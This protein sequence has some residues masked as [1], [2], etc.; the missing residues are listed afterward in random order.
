METRDYFLALY[1]FLDLW[2]DVWEELGSLLGREKMGLLIFERRSLT[3]LRHP[4]F[5]P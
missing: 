2:L 1:Q 4:C 3:R 5:S